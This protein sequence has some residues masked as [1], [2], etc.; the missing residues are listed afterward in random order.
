MA[1]S[2]E[3]HALTRE[4]LL[5]WTRIYHSAS[6]AG[7]ATGLDRSK[8]VKAANREGLTF[9]LKSSMAEAFDKYV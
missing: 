7:T 3:K 6:D 5:R 8:I 1:A 9:R 2:V 4:N